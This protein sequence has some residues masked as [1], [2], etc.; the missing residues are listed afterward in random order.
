[1]GLPGTE[2]PEFSWIKPVL[3]PERI[4]YIGLRDIDAGE[5]KILKDN[6]ECLSAKVP[7]LYAE[8]VVAHR[9]HRLLHASR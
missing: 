4:A 5:R 1:M 9:N 2:I 6:S 7:V 3:K 8:H